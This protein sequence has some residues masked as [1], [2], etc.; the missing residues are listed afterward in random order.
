MKEKELNWSVPTPKGPA[1]FKKSNEVTSKK[2]QGTKK[3]LRIELVVEAGTKYPEQRT[4]LYYPDPDRKVW[5]RVFCPD[6]LTI[7]G[8]FVCHCEKT[9]ETQGFHKNPIYTA[10]AVE[11]PREFLD[12]IIIEK[13]EVKERYRDGERR[14]EIVNGSQVEVK[15][16]DRTDTER[17]DDQNPQLREEFRPV[18]TETRE[19]SMVQVWGVSEIKCFKKHVEA[20]QIV[21]RES[22]QIIDE[23]EMDLCGISRLVVD[24]YLVNEACHRDFRLDPGKTVPTILFLAGKSKVG[25]AFSWGDDLPAWVKEEILAQLRI[26]VSCREAKTALGEST[27]PTCQ[28][29]Q[30]W[31]LAQE[32]I[33][34]E[35]SGNN[36][37][38]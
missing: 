14:H 27:C 18:F 1:E 31:Q 5:N 19:E 10:R 30:G 11:L 8:K 34:S 37:G 16:L 7:G 26:C 22:F 20:Q 35:K 15:R 3:L 9:G 32:V 24:Q 4:A 29:H 21:E 23:Q 28:L 33:K 17:I 13:Y 38:K 25:R 12:E 2:A 36:K 6:G